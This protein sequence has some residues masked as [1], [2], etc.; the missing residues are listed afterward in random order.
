MNYF[1]NGLL[2]AFFFLFNHQMFA[3]KIF[4]T[5]VLVIG[6]GTG[7][8]AAGIESARCGSE[9]IIAESG[10]WLG[11]MF[12]SAGVSASDG[13]DHL[14]SGLWNEFREILYKVYGGK[15][16]IA[17]GWVSNTMFEPH[18]ADSIFKSLAKKE[19]FLKVFYDYHFLKALKSHN[20]VTGA[21]FKNKNNELVN[22]YA[23]ITID[24]TELGDV[25]ANAGAGYDIGMEGN[26]ITHENVGVKESNNIIQDLTYTAI[27]K[28]YGPN[29]D[30]TITLP[31]NYNAAEFDCSTTKYC[32][33]INKGKPSVDAQQMLAY[34]KLPHQ[35]YLINWPKYGN[36]TYINNI[37]ENENKR[38]NDLNKAK[39]TTLRFIYFIQHELGYKNFGLADDEFPTPDK[40]PLIPYYRE[41]R[42]LKGLVKFS[43]LN[44]KDPFSFGDPLYRTGISVG[45]YPID[46]HHKKNLDAP[47]HL[48]FYPIPSFNV[49]AGTMITA[50]LNGLIVIEK[51]ISVTNVVNGTTRLQPCVLL[52]G[53]ASGVMA[54]LCVKN[55][56][57]PSSLPVRNLQQILLDHKAYIMPYIDVAP[58]DIDF[59]S[60]QKVGA[61]GIIK[62]KGIAHNWANQTW[63]YPDST[64]MAD[65]LIKGLMEYFPKFKCNKSLN[66]V[67]TS[68]DAIQ[69]LNLFFQQLHINKKIAPS[70]G[71]LPVTRRQLAVWLDK[72][73]G[74]FTFQGVDYKGNFIK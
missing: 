43:I 41:G 24:G 42:R 71:N 13:N 40:L 20:K 2:F 51:G 21:V 6:G 18:V 10:P 64:I 11:G 38:I 14:P 59:E 47:Q 4:H 61:T 72:Y 9:T 26:D 57:D 12:S 37:E 22:I 36:D 65:A 1:R 74:V 54:S 44:I 67:L 48:E 3:Q 58:S 53:Q 8:T 19:K 23:R 29:A 68:E 50:K 46:H 52:T 27:L 16:A 60:I 62:G 28:D 33:D 35:K 70:P 73:G 55:K 39:Q 63:F 49:P 30:K 32:H 45:D 25:F 5:E 17:T 66:S 15:D 56:C 34:G 31:N 7:G 69:L